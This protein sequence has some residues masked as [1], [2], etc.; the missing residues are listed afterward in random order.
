MALTPEEQ[1]ELQQLEQEQSS[2]GSQYEQLKNQIQLQ[3]QPVQEAPETDTI[4]ALARGTA[5]G[6][7]FDTADE[8]TAALESGLTSKPY[9]QALKESRAEY[10]ASEEQYPISSVVGGLAGGIGQAAA[11]GALTGGTGAVAGAAQTGSKLAKLG[12]LAKSA[13]LPSVEKSAIKNIGTAARTGA[14]M[15]GLTSIG[16]SEKDGLE[17]L[18][19]VPGGALTGG[20]VG[21]VLGGAV[22]GVKGAAGVIGG[23]LSKAADEGSLPFSFRKIRDL[24]R[25][26]KEGQGYVTE[27]ELSGIDEKFQDAAE[28][29]VNLIQSNLDNLRTIK[30]RILENVEEPISVNSP[31]SNLLAGLQKSASENLADAEPALKRV[32]GLYQGKMNAIVNEAGDIS[33]KSANDLASQLEDYIQS[34]PEISSEVKTLFKNTIKD[35]KLNLRYSVKSEKAYMALKDSPETSDLYK[36]Y[37]QEIPDSALETSDALSPDEKKFFT[38]LKAS[39]TRKSK[40]PEFKKQQ[41]EMYQEALKEVK[42]RRTTK[43][44]TKEMKPDEAPMYEDLKK[45]IQGIMQDAASNNPLAKLD[46]MMH[47]ILNASESLGGVTRGEGTALK[48]KFKVFDVMRGVTSETGSGQKAFMRYEQAISDLEKSSPKLAAAFREITEP[49][50]IELENKKFLEGA[51]LGEGPKESTVIKQFVTGPAT[52]VAG[53]A[54]NI[55]AQPGFSLPRLGVTGLNYMKQQIDNRLAKSPESITYKTFSES[56]QRAIESKDEARRAAI[57]NTLMQY[58]AFREMFKTEESK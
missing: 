49:R 17:R 26:G 22:E 51:K 10:K 58:K 45:E 7:T 31:I 21:G 5:Q 34:N 25:S 11:V 43:I 23:K 19:D 15:G 39:I 57:L 42:K 30:N 24:W 14:L 1:L 47:N 37:I 28:E 20:I 16:A 32:E 8:I 46:V 52:Q 56:L 4:E 54:A 3:N 55:M 33:A 18:E 29:S 9:E 36:K 50:I 12:S 27:K 53:Q 44:K 41:D 38:N 48:R 13:L 6:L 35:I 40:T 2:L